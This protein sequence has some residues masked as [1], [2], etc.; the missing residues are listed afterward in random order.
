MKK[1]GLIGGLGPESTIPYYRGILYGV[2]KRVGGLYFP[3]MLIDS[4]ATFDIIRM[5]AD[6]DRAGMLAAF[7]ASIEN[8]AA[9]GAE[10]GA[11]ACNTGHMVFEELAARSP[12]PL[13][14]ILDVTRRECERRGFHRLA[15]LGTAATMGGTFYR[16]PFE[17]AGMAVITPSR[18]EQAY[19]AEHIVN[20][21]ELGRVNPE[22]VARTM[23]IARRL[24]EDES[25]DAIILGC[26]ELPLLFK[27]H[28]LPVPVIDTMQLHIAA[29]VD[30]ILAD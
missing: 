26:T 17:R 5:G 30:A 22:T 8:L 9:A 6:G 19:I 3:P 4:L 27:D 29:L 20:E 16:E 15:L 13:V 23:S 12:I 14:S 2:Q 1:L 18:A 21:L 11:L 7:T 25:A 10:I 28:T 24:I